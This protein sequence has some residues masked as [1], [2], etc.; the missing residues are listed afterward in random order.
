MLVSRIVAPRPGETVVDACTGSGG[1]AMH[2]AALMENRG[3]VVACDVVP[4]KLDAVARHAARLGATIVEPRLLAAARLVE[5]LPLGADRVL[6]DAPCSGLGVIRR[7]PEFKWRIHPE[8]LPVLGARQRAMLEDAAAA[9]RPGGLLV[10]SVCTFELD[11]GPAAIAGFLEAH[12]EFDPE[13]IAGPGVGAIVAPAPNGSGDAF[14]YP[15][16][17]GTD[18]FFV[19]A[20]RRQ[21]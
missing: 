14:L 21:P 9:V 2:L 10:F 6:V 4:A 16:L 17:H 13:P 8:Q 5:A 20:C 1:K 7:R 3:R 15:H 18:G 11:E 12:P 19:A